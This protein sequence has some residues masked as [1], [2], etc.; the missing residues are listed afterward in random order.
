MTLVTCIYGCRDSDIYGGRGWDLAV[1]QSTLV[2]LLNLNKPLVLF[3]DHESVER[4]EKFLS[5]YAINDFKVIG[6]SLSTFEFHDKFMAFKKDIYESIVA[7]NRNE[8]LCYSKAFWVKQALD[9]KYFNSD[10]AFWVDAGLT[11]HGIFPEK[12]G[13]VEMRIP[14][15]REWYYPQNPN[16][17]FNPQLA[18]KIYD[19]L[20]LSKI[21]SCALPMQG[22]VGDQELMIQEHYKLEHKP[23]LLKHVIGGIFGGHKDIYNIFFERYKEMLNLYIDKRMY[24][25]EEPILSALYSIFPEMFDLKFFDLWWFFSPGER[26]SYLS[27][28]ANSFYKV[29]A[30]YLNDV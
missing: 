21:F 26:T 23:Q 6:Q 4:T 16:N 2:N 28:E 30:N 27:G 10:V 19:K 11:H 5:E 8:V 15:K 20:D 9:N 13:G 22:M 14:V 7:K 1:Y 12:F 29:F 17:M 3:T 18:N 24:G 25:T